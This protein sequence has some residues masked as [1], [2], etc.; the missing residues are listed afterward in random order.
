[1]KAVPQFY[2]V[3]NIHMTN[4]VILLKKERVETDLRQNIHMNMIR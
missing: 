2:R 4:A 1:M 3:M